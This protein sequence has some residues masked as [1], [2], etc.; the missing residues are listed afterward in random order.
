MFFIAISRLHANI[1]LINAECNDRERIVMPKSM[2]EGSRLRTCQAECLEDCSYGKMVVAQSLFCRRFGFEYE[3]MEAEDDIFIVVAHACCRY[4][5]P[6]R[7]ADLLRIRTRAMGSQ[8]RTVRFDY[9]I[10]NPFALLI[11]SKCV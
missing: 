1:Q 9:E 2:L 3:R 6:A 11:S 10:L 5:R 7:F 4:R 8:R